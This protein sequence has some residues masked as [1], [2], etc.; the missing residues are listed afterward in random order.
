[1]ELGRNVQLMSIL[2]AVLLATFVWDGLFSVVRS[3]MSEHHWE[4]QMRMV[5]LKQLREGAKAAQLEAELERRPEPVGVILGLSTAYRGIDP[6]LLTVPGD[7]HWSNRAANGGT[8]SQLSYYTEPLLASDVRPAVVLI[9]AHA[10]WLAERGQL[11]PSE[12]D[13]G[14]AS[15]IPLIGRF[16]WERN[17]VRLAI[18]RSIRRAR[19]AILRALGVEMSVVFPGMARDP[20]EAPPAFELAHAGAGHMANL[21]DL[22]ERFNWFEEAAYH[23]DSP[24]VP[25]L[26]ALVGRL[27]ALGAK[28]VVAVMPEP[29]RHRDRPPARARA[30]LLE[31]LASIPDAVV[32]DHWDALDD[33]ALFFD[34][35]H[36]NEEGR[37]VYSE[38]LAQDLSSIVRRVLS[39]ADTRS[40][41]GGQ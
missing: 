19:L 33:D 34:R 3:R 31:T 35:M 8:F 9:A 10:V 18:D 36:L 30:L 12:S 2:L 6:R 38:L 15:W 27:Q 29:P 7:L 39:R 16:L 20:W 13:G 25:E 40:H 41:R 26:R 28:V 24:E 1:M 4:V 17:G 11:S 32:L 23:S 21:D 5:P 14:F 22:W 37:R